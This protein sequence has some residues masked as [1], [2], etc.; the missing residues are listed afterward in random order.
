MEI[1]KLDILKK[2]NILYAEDD[3]TIREYVGKTL[4]MMCNDVF[5]AKNG[6]EAINI[7]N[8][9]VVHIIILDYVMPLMDGYEVAKKIRKIDKAIP[10]IMLS[11][12]T[13]KEKLLKA[14]ELN[15]I[16]YIEKPLSY[17]KVLLALNNAIE[18]LEDNNRLE[19]ILTDNIKYN[20]INKII[21]N[22]NNIIQLS[23]QESLFFELLI[24]KKNT[25]ISKELIE[26]RVFFESVDTNTMRN[27][28]YRLRKKI[29]E[30]IIVTVKDF[31]YLLKV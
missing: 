23:K 17:D 8:T 25:L 9:E 26:D 7:F 11:G 6:V 3:I 12:H 5:F 18:S 1:K 28:V 30:D 4:S 19:I 15:L 24:A 27:M 16:T 29:G 13:D 10:I 2:L 21:V 22:K 14:I 20:F 31:G